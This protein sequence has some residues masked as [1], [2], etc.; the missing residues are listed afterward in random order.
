MKSKIVLVFGFLLCLIPYASLYGIPVY[1]LGVFF[2]IKS[3]EKRV[4][5]IF[6]ISITLFL[7]AIVY[8]I[9]ILYIEKMTG[10]G[11]TL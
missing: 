2:L 3:D 1:L 9:L 5:K 8:F 4:V 6:W 10:E 7:L 11:F